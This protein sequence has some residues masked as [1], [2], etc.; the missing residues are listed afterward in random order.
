LCESERNKERFFSVVGNFEGLYWEPSSA[1]EMGKPTQNPLQ[2][3]ILPLSPIH[4]FLISL[5][6]SFFIE[7]LIS[8]F[9][10]FQHINLILEKI[11]PTALIFNDFHMDV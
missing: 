10:Q 5:F 3:T 8:S 2:L 6:I 9:E 11:T 7:F 4:H 1:S